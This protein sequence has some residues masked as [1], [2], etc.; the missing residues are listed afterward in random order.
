MSQ[1]AGANQDEGG[2]NDTPDDPARNGGS[3]DEPDHGDGLE[4]DAFELPPIALEVPPRDPVLGADHGGL[5]SEVGRQPFGDR[6][7]AVR[8]DGNEDRVRITYRSEVVRRVHAHGPVAFSIDNPETRLLHRFQVRSAG[9]EDDVDAGARQPSAEEPTDR[10]RAKDCE[11][12]ARVRLSATIRR[13]TFPVGV[14]GM[15]STMCS[16]LGTLKSASRSRQ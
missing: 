2:I 8:L 3:G 13:W 11:P 7:Q 5:V 4:M 9:D 12:H 15:D 16:R 10:A 6:G 1:A 14:R